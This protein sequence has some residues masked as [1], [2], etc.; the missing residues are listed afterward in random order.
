MAERRS[1]RLKVVLMVAEREEQA[2]GVRLGEAKQALEREEAQLSQLQ[3]YRAQYLADYRQQRRG[4]DARALMS[5]SGFLQ[6]L[7]EALG[8][9]EQK[10]AQ[11]RQQ[12][13]QR[14]EEWQQKYHRR[15]SL[16]EMI[17]RMR[18]EES[19]VLEQRE[20]RELDDLAAQRM[21]RADHGRKR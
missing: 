20:Q 8:G 1:E 17:E 12:L 19:A 14:R 6:R 9:Q 11:V 15:Q 2:A 7:G 18:R 10:L 21:N 4:V 13:D 3:D 5:Y 16:A